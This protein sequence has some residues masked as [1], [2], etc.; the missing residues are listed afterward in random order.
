MNSTAP[1]ATPTTTAPAPPA[2][3]TVHVERGMLAAAERLLR[4]TGRVT[5]EE[6]FAGPDDPVIE[7]VLVDDVEAIRV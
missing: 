7:F 3:I 4:A 6:A 5:F 1:A 2:P